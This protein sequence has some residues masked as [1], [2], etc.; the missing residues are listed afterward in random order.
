MSAPDSESNGVGPENSSGDDSSKINRAFLED[1]YE[2]YFDRIYRYCSYRLFAKEAAEDATATVFLRLAERVG[3]FE[4]K[5]ELELRKWLYGTARNAVSSHWR[6]RK[7]RMKILGAICEE[8]RGDL[9]HYGDAEGSKG[10]DW[11][12]LYLAMS[13]LNAKQQHFV[14]LRFFEGYRPKEVAELLGIRSITVRVTVSR[15]LKKL[16]KYLTEVSYY[17][18]GKD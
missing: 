17:E 3:E 14:T 11:S 4:R 8:R 13:R 1:V 9:E 6:S 5:N 2:R 12:N 15:A 10:V 16:R 18:V 7:Q